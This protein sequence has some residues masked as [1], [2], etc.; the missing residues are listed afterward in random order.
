MTQNLSYGPFQKSAE[1]VHSTD[2]LTL[3]KKL[4]ILT[5]LLVSFAPISAISNKGVNVT[6][7]N[8]QK[9]SFSL[10]EEVIKITGNIRDVN[11]EPMVGVSVVLKGTNT[12]TVT[13]IMVGLR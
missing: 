10:A 3:H 7:M 13:D 2:K 4:V 6:A 8:G 12:G 9:T 11:N 5:L 1:H